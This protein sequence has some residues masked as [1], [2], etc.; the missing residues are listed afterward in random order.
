[1]EIRRG[2]TLVDDGRTDDGR[3]VKIE[4]EFW[5]AEFAIMFF[6]K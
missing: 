6:F 4:L 2:V 5:E 1:M 3:N